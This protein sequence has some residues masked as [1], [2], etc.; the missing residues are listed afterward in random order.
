VSQTAAD[1][2]RDQDRP[3]RTKKGDFPGEGLGG[4]RS[5]KLVRDM[6]RFLSGGESE[7][8]RVFVDRRR[9]GWVED[10][11]CGCCCFLGNAGGT[12]VAT[13]VVTTSLASML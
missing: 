5:S 7:G 12:E 1:K 6:L 11:V 4:L 8:R 9:K 2:R 3:R 10:G 13:G